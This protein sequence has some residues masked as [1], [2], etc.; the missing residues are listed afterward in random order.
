MELLEILFKEI[1]I[2]KKNFKSLLLLVF[3][4]FFK[5]KKN[6]KKRNYIMLFF[7]CLDILL[8]GE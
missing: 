6:V 1:F 4:V 5:L 3:N 8:M 2:I 7:L